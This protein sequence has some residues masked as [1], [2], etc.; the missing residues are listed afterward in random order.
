MELAH[1]EDFDWQDDPS[2]IC[3]EQAAT[4][5]YSNV[6]GAVVIR[7]AQAWDENSDTLIILEPACARRAAR[8][9]LELLAALD[10]RRTAEANKIDDE[11]EQQPST[12]ALRQRR[13]R[14]RHRNGGVTPESVTDGAGV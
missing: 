9:I 7:Q 4:A 10:G 14:E 8:A 5:V 1:A 6:H 3:R 2:I 12:N 11:A 13:Y